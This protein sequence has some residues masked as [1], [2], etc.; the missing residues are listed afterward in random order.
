MLTQQAKTVSLDSIL[1]GLD[2]LS[3]TKAR[4]RGSNHGRVLVETALVRLGRLEDLVSLS[5]LSQW[6]NPQEAGGSKGE[7]RGSK[8]ASQRSKA[9]HQGPAIQD[10]KTRIEMQGREESTGSDNGFPLSHN[11]SVLEP[12]SSVLESASSVPIPELTEASL[13][14]TWSQVVAQLGPMLVGNLE[15]SEGVA[16][17]GPK[18]LVLR[19]PSRYNHE[20]QYC[21]LSTSM[22]RIQEAIRKVTGQSWNVRIE[23]TGGHS[24]PAQVKSEALDSAPSSYRRL[25]ADA[26]QEPLVKRALE[27][28]GAQIVHVDDGFGATRVETLER[29]ETANSEEAEAS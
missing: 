21:Q 13:R 8:I 24:A 1:A 12:R 15:K 20:Q 6:L 7:D 4:L 27:Q 14:E 19:F 25:R 5:Q 29:T 17:S 3:A 26:S 11:P 10:P 28:L 23:S 9:E 16:I 18:T 2:I 22:T